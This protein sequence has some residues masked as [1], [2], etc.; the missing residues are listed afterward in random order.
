M[1]FIKK[2]LQK[3]EEPIGAPTGKSRA[4]SV[5]TE[6]SVFSPYTVQAETLTEQNV[7]VSVFFLL[8]RQSSACRHVPGFRD[9]A[10]DVTQC[11]IFDI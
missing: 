2:V 10:V 4:S 7:S 11:V 5:I 8:L 9:L 3:L 6:E 1:A